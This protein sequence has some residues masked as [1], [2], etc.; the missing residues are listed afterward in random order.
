MA[1]PL[2][3]A[4]RLKLQRTR[5]F[6]QELATELQTYRDSK[7]LTA[8]RAVV[9]QHVIKG[10]EVS[11]TEHGLKP[12]AII[13]DAIHNMR[14]ALD[15]MASELAR[16]NGRSDKSVYFP[17]AADALSFDAAIK[18]QNF[19]KAGSDAVALLKQFAPYCGGNEALR[20]VHDLD[21]QDKHK[22]LVPTSSAMAFNVEGT[23]NVDKPDEGDFTVTAENIRYIFPAES[24]FAGQ[25]IIETL[26]QLVELVDGIVEAFAR[27]VEAR[28][29]VVA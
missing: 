1:D 8:G 12:G 19:H 24:V 6:I 15:L 22:A 23:F 17:F 4:W 10:V 13:G 29:P 5:Q 28:P 9:E 7:P 3:A 16:L 2:F 11:W 26:K 14:T 18:S 21:I 20:A 27:M 25:D